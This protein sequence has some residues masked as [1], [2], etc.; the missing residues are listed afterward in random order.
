MAPVQTTY[1]ENIRPAVEGQLADERQKSIK[2]LTV[3]NSEGVGFG[4]PVGYG[5]SGEQCKPIASGQAT[6]FAGITVR[7]RSVLTGEKFSQYESARVITEGPVWVKVAQTV[8]PGDTAYVRPS[9]GDF[10]KDN[11]NSGV[12]IAGRF[13]TA[14]TSGNLARLMLNGV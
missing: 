11:T 4:K 1:N 13:E 3:E 10:Q 9:N 12:A 6:V 8:A 2:S 5:S 7:D 14:A